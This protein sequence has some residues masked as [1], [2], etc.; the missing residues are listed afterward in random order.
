MKRRRIDD[1]TALRDFFI[2]VAA[3]DSLQSVGFVL[4]ERITGRLRCC[5][6]VARRRRLAGAARLVQWHFYRMMPR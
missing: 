1:V 5:L 4:G 3:G 6:T 2:G